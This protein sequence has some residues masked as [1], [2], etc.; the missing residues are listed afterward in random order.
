MSGFGGTLVEVLR[1]GFGGGPRDPRH[2]D[3]VDVAARRELADLIAAYLRGEIVT[4]RFSTRCNGLLDRTADTDIRKVVLTL[5]YCLE[6]RMTQPTW[7][8]QEQ[9]HALLRMIAFLN[10]EHRL[11]PRIFPVPA[12]QKLAANVVLLLWVVALVAGPVG[13]LV[14]GA[15]W[16]RLRR[17]MCASQEREVAAL[18]AFVPFR[19]EADWHEHE[20][21]LESYS[22][23]PYDPVRYCPRLPGRRGPWTFF[24]REVRTENPWTPEPWGPAAEIAALPVALII[25][26]RSTVL[27]VID[28][29]RPSCPP[30]AA[31]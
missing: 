15:L 27:P 19:S 20:G 26:Q 5:Q 9:W 31:P 14:I 6:D 7:L 30:T 12:K 16:W 1:R 18:A 23:P 8:S 3:G 10:T 17:T 24:A 11:T 2:A 13:W 4:E 21:V 28:E 29:C 25:V 22:L